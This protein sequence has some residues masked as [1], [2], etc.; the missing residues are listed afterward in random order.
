[1]QTL[2][3]NTLL[4]GGRY[5]IIKALGD[6]SFGIT[7]LAVHTYLRKQVAIKEFFMKTHNSRGN[8]GSVT[9]ISESSQSTYYFQKFQKEAAK[10]SQL[11][12]PNIVTVSDM[13]AENGTFYYVMDYIEGQDLKEYT[14]NHPLCE[15]EAVNIIKCVA[16]ALTYMHEQQ[17]M[18]HLDLKPNNI[19]RRESDGCIFLIDFGLSKYFDKNGD[20]ESS[21]NIGG[22]TPGY[23]PIEQATHTQSGEFRPTI[24][25][26]ALGAT[27]YKLLT[28]TTPPE[29]YMLVSDSK[30]IESNLRAKG[31]SEH[32]IP[33]ITEAM[34][35]NVRMRTQTVRDFIANLS[36]TA[37]TAYTNTKTTANT[38]QTTQRVAPTSEE[39]MF[40]APKNHTSASTSEETVAAKPNTN[41]KQEDVS[42]L[43]FHGRIGRATYLSTLFGLGLSLTLV[44]V[45]VSIIMGAMNSKLGGSGPLIIMVYYLGLFY[46]GITLGAKRCHD[47][48]RSGWFQIIPLYG[49]VMIFAKGEGSENKYGTGAKGISRKSIILLSKIIAGIFIVTVILAFMTRTTLTANT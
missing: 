39:T 46:I 40:A 45:F 27:L 20:P 16:E 43:N 17:H 29:A 8:D 21:T 10:L 36:G 5:K 41:N 26:Y 35:P 25:V 13:F 18:L 33:V 3:P 11:S 4:Q 48:G 12:H 31:V 34:C 1:M 38:E 30:L 22:G 23:S 7:Y 37:S 32:L 19:M 28:G 2:Q 14:E 47:L 49:F 42:L 9:N 44:I 6:G 24:D 15:G